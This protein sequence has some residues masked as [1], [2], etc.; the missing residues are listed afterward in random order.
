MFLL[1][2][3]TFLGC[4]RG[5]VLNLA[6]DKKVG[7]DN[8][9]KEIKQSDWFKQTNSVYNFLLKFGNCQRNNWQRLSIVT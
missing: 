1:S 8:C 9:P 6:I 4:M 7:L 3:E 5:Q 2:T